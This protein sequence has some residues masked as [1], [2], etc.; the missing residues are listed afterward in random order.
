MNFRQ[1]TDESLELTECRR[2]VARN[3]TYAPVISGLG[4]LQKGQY[5][6]ENEIMCKHSQKPQILRPTQ[7]GKRGIVR[8]MTRKAR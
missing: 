8:A 4:Q 1:R 3:R 7:D 6:Y 2:A 5:I